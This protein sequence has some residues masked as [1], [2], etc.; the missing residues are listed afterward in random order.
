MKE[1]HVATDIY[2]EIHHNRRF[3]E[4]RHFRELM[5]YCQSLGATTIDWILDDMWAL[6]ESYPGGID[7]LKCAID[8]AHERG[9]EFHVVYKPFEGGLD[10]VE[11]PHSFPRPDGAVLWEDVRGLL[12]I[13]RPFIAAH[14]EMCMKRRPGD[15]DSGGSLKAVRLIGRDDGPL[16]LL[17]EDLSVRVSKTNGRFVPWTGPFTLAQETEWRPLFPLG[18]TCRV[19]TLDG[20]DIPQGLRYIEVR[21]AEGAFRGKTFRN[22]LEALVELVN[23]RGEVIP[24][25]PAT[26]KSPGPWFVNN[27]AQPFMLDLVRYGQMPEARAFLADRARAADRAAEMRTYGQAPTDRDYALD[28]KL[29][30]AVARGKMPY[31]WNHLN[32]VYPEVRQEWLRVVKSCIER[33]A[34]AVNF[35]A[36]HHTRLQENWA[37]GF[38]EPV[39]RELEGEVDP[40][41]ARR[42]IGNTY[43][44]FLRE[45]RDLLHAHGRKIG[46]HLLSNFLKPRD[47]DPRV[48]GY[49][50][51]NPSDEN[52]EFQWQKWVSEIA[53]LAVFRGAMGYRRESLYD[54]VN[55]FARAC[56]EAGIP[57]VYQSNRRIFDNRRDALRLDPDRLRW[58]DHEMTYALGHR[59]LCAYQLYETA[60]FTCLDEDGEFRGSGEVLS[61][62]RKFGFAA[63]AKGPA[64]E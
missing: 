21:F 18:R 4:A 33:G 57:L 38:N 29:Q 36:S 12:P 5:A 46:V 37:Y 41:A 31:M 20:L 56:R 34:D 15:E 40:A 54:I 19:L 23:E 62:A 32:P 59:G 60:N 26:G 53:D 6:Y 2:D 47:E 10:T 3:Y 64:T 49:G 13:V 45:A 51:G 48:S 1:L 14:P 7:L 11:L 8:A 58:L 39:L 50:L 43:T 28:E 24:S 30:V 63:G 55:C 25:T 9:L 42:V 61:I 27:L 44:D 17:P 52:V 16:G 35:R 22:E